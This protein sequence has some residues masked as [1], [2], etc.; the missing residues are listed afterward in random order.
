MPAHDCAGF[1]PQL[2]ESNSLEPGT[3]DGKKLPGFLEFELGWWRSRGWLDVKSF[4]QLAERPV[5][6][7]FDAR[8]RLLASPIQA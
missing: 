6:K 4:K 1:I 3:I 2:N 8:T 7:D 5:P